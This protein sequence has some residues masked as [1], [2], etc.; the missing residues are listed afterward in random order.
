MVVH[1][2]DQV[3]RG[4][5]AN[6]AIGGL[7]VTTATT[8]P[9]RWLGRTARVELRLDGQEGDWLHGDGKVLRILADRLAISLE[10]RSPGLQRVI[11]ELSG[12]SHAHSRVMHVVLID[13]DVVRRTQMV[14]AFRG[15]GCTV[16]DAA[17]PLEA[18]V[19]LGESM[20]EPD[21]IAIA[22]SSPADISEELRTFVEREHPRAKLVAIGE[23]PIDPAGV[24]H[25]LSSSD[26]ADDMQARVREMLGRPRGT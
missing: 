2:S 5:I 10:T 1:V 18:I 12:L 17:S 15:A 11:E 8:A 16:V 22:N 9:A 25:W 6:L 3:Q 14:T 13:D 4:R 23:A 21:V 26:P 24:M 7:L 19:R 20:F